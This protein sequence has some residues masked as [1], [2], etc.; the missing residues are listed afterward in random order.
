MSTDKAVRA[1][2]QHLMEGVQII[3]F[4]PQEANRQEGNRQQ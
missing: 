4:T 1:S 3:G 2:I